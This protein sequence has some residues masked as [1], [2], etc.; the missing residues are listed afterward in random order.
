MPNKTVAVITI[1]AS[2]RKVVYMCLAV[3]L[4]CIV[5]CVY[6]TDFRTK[7]LFITFGVRLHHLRLTHPHRNIIFLFRV[8]DLN[9]AWVQQDLAWN[10]KCNGLTAYQLYFLGETVR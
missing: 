7:K 5:L 2:E 3:E 4:F 6:E 1:L 9:R 8:I 10:L